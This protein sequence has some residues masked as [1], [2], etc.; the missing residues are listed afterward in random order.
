MRL[1]FTATVY[2]FSSNPSFHCVDVPAAISAAFDQKGAVPVSGT[3]NGCEWRGTLL[4]NGQGGHRM[5]LNGQI[6]KQARVGLGQTI[7]IALQL[8]EVSRELAMPDELAVALRANDLLDQFNALPPGLQRAVLQRL[9]TAKTRPT[10]ER[11]VEELVARLAA[12]H[13]RRSK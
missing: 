4:P 13:W 6:R 8:D 10:W 9:Q 2:K 11:R 3:V 1:R 12:N 7:E 5:V